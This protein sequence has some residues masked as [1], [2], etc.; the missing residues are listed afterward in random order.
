MTRRFLQVLGVA[1]LIV[2]IGIVLKVTGV[3]L[4]S[5]GAGAEKATLT[6]AWGDPDLQ[7]IWREDYETPL[8]RP[9]MFAGKEFLTDEERAELDRIRSAAP[10][11]NDVGIAPRGSEQDLSG[12][13]NSVFSSTRHTGRRTS[14]I[15]DPPMEESLR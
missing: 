3:G 13:Y 2:S 14:L 15:V 10:R 5:K 12:A 7:G 4:A 9:A 6:T 11:D 8:Q 1:I